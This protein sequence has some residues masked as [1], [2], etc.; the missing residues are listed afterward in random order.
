MR[1][2]DSQ[3]ALSPVV[4]GILLVI[5][6]IALATTVFLMADRAREANLKDAPPEM[7]FII[8]TTS[9]S[10]QVVQAPPPPSQ[11]DWFTDLR[12]GGTCSPTLNGVPF[13]TE[14]GTLV[15]A[16]DV[17]GCDWEQ[18]LT[19]RSSPDKGNALLFRYTF[20]N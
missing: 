5:V 6:V 3:S 13:P 2:R 17:L 19:I 15:N 16:D 8:G 9:P 11:L 14:P 10:V 4:G 1:F 12:I 20:H 7:G 18:S